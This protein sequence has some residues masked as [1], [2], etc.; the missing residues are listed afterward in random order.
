MSPETEK[1]KSFT[2]LRAWQEG[3]KLVLMIYELAKKFP[4]DEVFGLTIQLR[5][6]A[7]SVTS[8]IAEGFS[9][10]SYKEK[11]QFYSIALGSVTEVQNQLLIARDLSYISR[12]EFDRAANQSVIVNKIINGLIRASKSF[13]RNS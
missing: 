11:I 6:A 1:I 7:V 2:D 8:N 5:R 10:Q 9:R 12:G 3:H 4:K 13:I